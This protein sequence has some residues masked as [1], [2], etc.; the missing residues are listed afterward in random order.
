MSIL[1][2]AFGC[3][4]E[5]LYEDKFTLPTEATQRRA[6]K[7]VNVDVITYEQ[8]RGDA[9]LESWTIDG[10]DHFLEEKTSLE[11]FSRITKW[12]LAQRQLGESSSTSSSSSSSPTTKEEINA[13]EKQNKEE[14]ATVSRIEFGAV[15]A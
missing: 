13:V 2:S 12:L 9:S 8:C 5:R 7:N 15:E 1:S 14:D 4:S 3:K 11:L 10:T 6:P